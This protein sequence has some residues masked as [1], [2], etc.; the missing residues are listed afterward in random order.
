VIIIIKITIA[1]PALFFV[2]VGRI[3]QV[4]AVDLGCGNT[5]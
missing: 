4:L 1:M 2:Y 5:Q 3:Q